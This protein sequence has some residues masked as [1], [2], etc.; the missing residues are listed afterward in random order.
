VLRFGVLEKLLKE[1][2]EGDVRFDAGA[3]ALYSTDASNYRH[4]PIGVVLPKNADD[5]RRTVELCRK[6]G[7]PILSRGAG[8][9]LAGQTCNTAVIM[10]FSK[11]MNH[12][13]EIDAVKRTAIVEPGV[14]LDHLRLEAEKYDLT[15]GPDPA[16]HSRCTLGGMIGNNSCGVHSILAG[17]TVDNVQ[18]LDILTYDGLR[19]TVGPTSPEE[20][21]AKIQLGG[22][23]GQIYAALKSLRDRYQDQIRKRFPKLPRRVSGFN[24]EELLPENGFNVARALVGT[25]G[26]CVTVLK[27][28]LRLV[29]WPKFRTL[30]VIGY[31]D[32][33]Q[34]ADASPAIRATGVIGLEGMD[35]DMVMP[36]K[37]Y[38]GY[39]EKIAR[40]PT[41]NAWLLA[42]YGAD[43]EEEAFAKA[44]A[45]AH[46]AGQP[47]PT[48]VLVC[49]NHEDSEAAWTL[50]ESAL[51][52][53]AFIPG[54]PDRME[55][56]EDTAVPPDKFGNYLR[57]LRKLYDK[58]NYK[59]AFYGHFGDGCL[60]T[61][62]SFDLRSEEGR[63]KTKQFLNEATDLVVRY[64]GSLS[65]EHGD[66]QAR[67]ELLPKMFGPELV[68]AFA[69]FKGIWDPQ[70][71]MNPGKVV[72]PRGMMDDLRMPPPPSTET[73]FS[74]SENHGGFSRA[75]AL[76]VGVGRCRKEE[77]GLMCPSYQITR[78]EA[79]STRGRAHLLDEM[80]RAETIKDGWKSEEVKEALDLCLAC[81]GC[82]S[83]CP[84]N[85]DM[86]SYKAEFL[87]HYYDGK[88]RPRQA[89]AFG[90]VMKWLRLGSVMPR[91]ANFFTQTPGLSSLAK[92]MA[93]AA[94]ERTI[95]P[96]ALQTLRSWFN[97]PSTLHPS[98]STDTGR[99]VLLWPDTFTNYLNP[100]GGQAAVKV[101]EH[102]G[103]NVQLPR[104]GLCCGRP[105]YDYGFLPLAKKMLRDILD[106]LRPEIEAGMPLI[107]L[108]PS[109]VAVFRDELCN[110]FPND[111]LAQKLKN[112]TFLFSEFL[113]KENIPIVTP[114]DRKPGP[115]KSAILQT[116]CHQK[117]VL[118]ASSD[119]DLLKKCGITVT[120]PESGC[121]GMAGSFGFEPD[122]TELA[123]ALGERALLP[124]I[125]NASANI[126]VIADGFSCQEQIRQGTSKKPKH[127]AEIIY[128]TLNLLA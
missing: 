74:Y 23:E 81:K 38:R 126:A 58:F 17:K 124:A 28:T 115:I 117:S 8:T 110:L 14:I 88:L 114:A 94:P 111:P 67:A 9:S 11:H 83:E 45:A 25:E 32:V 101:L 84:T 21:E 63:I 90:L 42:E 82:K 102:L 80:L 85:I 12:I 108:E 69:E 72:N 26:T 98:P 100:T 34:A 3:K 87:S 91:V 57:E 40:L 22:R 49:R 128:E 7:V 51:A 93:G 70:N 18:T 16:T 35:V 36:L 55:G 109:C 123:N 68:Q 5:V 4:I 54:E 119:R 27:A 20:L 2:L 113:L 122:H 106:T 64:G 15:F 125:R 30:V 116:H 95:P 120:E 31:E 99:T 103:Y 10:D 1:S 118:T 59:G 78:N 33:F 48:A 6:S 56:W 53:T 60:H 19:M 47:A 65:G 112:Q 43:T 61:R 46:S 62:I 13:F 97:K 44:E 73:H 96:L 76:C 41:G 86:A 77:G 79:D 29:P 127:I 52:A 104:A 66:G 50:R 71:K 39:A 92:W 105:L 107:G 121:C 75:V 24:L 89:Y 37:R